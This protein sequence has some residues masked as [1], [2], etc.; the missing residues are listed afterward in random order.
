MFVRPIGDKEEM[1]EKVVEITKIFTA[2]LS[3]DVEMGIER[4]M[5]NHAR[6]YTRMMAYD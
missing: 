1:I 3:G 4:S 5:Y 6:V 2:R